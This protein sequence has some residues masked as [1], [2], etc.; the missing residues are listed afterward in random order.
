MPS[1]SPP[2]PTP[3][4]TTTSSSTTVSSHDRQRSAPT[5]GNLSAGRPARNNPPEPLSK[6][7]R[8]AGKNTGD[9][10][11]SRLPPHAPRGEEKTTPPKKTLVEAEVAAATAAEEAT[12]DLHYASSLASSLAR[13]AEE[14]AGAV[15]AAAASDFETIFARHKNGR[16]SGSNGNGILNNSNNND[17]THITKLKKQI[18]DAA[19]LRRGQLRELRHALR[20]DVAVLS[21][22]GKASRDEAV[23]AD[24]AMEAAFRGA[25]SALEDAAGRAAERVRKMAEMM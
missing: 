6:L 19:E 7:S 22:E 16:S 4:P 15:A 8:G 5:E 12:T 14:K 24:A 13:S 2:N 21:R 11:A 10:S 1:S 18:K 3:T 25:S 20:G 23:R 17:K 9:A